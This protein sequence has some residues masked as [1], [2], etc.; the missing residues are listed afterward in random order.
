MQLFHHQIAW[1][2]DVEKSD[3]T[4]HLILKWNCPVSNHIVMSMLVCPS[5]PSAP[6]IRQW[7]GP[8]L[9]QVMACR[10]FGDK[11]LPEPT[12]VYCQLD[13][14]EQISVKFDSKFYHFHSRKCIWNCRLPKWRSFHPVKLRTKQSMRCRCPMT[15][16]IWFRYVLV[17]FK[18][19]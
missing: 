10:L 4:C 2:W 3:N 17:S 13:S 16:F 1:H 15:Y 7:T 19:R 18:W 9:V 14:W 5:P 6:Y 12:L 11:L 8:A